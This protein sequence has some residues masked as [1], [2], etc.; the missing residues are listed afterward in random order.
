MVE[1]AVAAR[2]FLPCPAHQ[3]A[4]SVWFWLGE[5]LSSTGTVWTSASRRVGVLESSDA[6]AVCLCLRVE[7]QINPKGLFFSPRRFTVFSG[8]RDRPSPSSGSMCSCGQL[9]VFS[10]LLV[11]VDK[12][13][14]FPRH[15][16]SFRVKARG[17]TTR[18][19]PLFD[20]YSYNPSKQNMVKTF[21]IYIYI[22]IYNTVTTVKPVCGL[23][24]KRTCCFSS[25]FMPRRSIILHGH[26]QLFHYQSLSSGDGEAETYQSGVRTTP[27]IASDILFVDF[28]KKK[29]T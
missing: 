16:S 13:T 2:P 7:I 6:V 21:T 3:L 11:V 18:P 5:F 24:V 25:C 19:Q 29:N 14:M 1:L 15:F 27:R 10:S 8:D 4:A 26:I 17:L 22:Y 20:C 9:L 23:E 12:H 28:F